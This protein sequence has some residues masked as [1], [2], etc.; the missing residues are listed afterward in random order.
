M[1]ISSASR[2]WNDSKW[3]D[4]CRRHKIKYAHE[5]RVTSI[6]IDFLREANDKGQSLQERSLR[7]IFLTT[8]CSSGMSSQILHD[9]SAGGNS[10]NRR[11]SSCRS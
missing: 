9:S 7:H 10:A 5:W 3:R 4:A 6:R 8:P 1:E 2:R 11:G